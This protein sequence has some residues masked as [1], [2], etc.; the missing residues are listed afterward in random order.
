MEAA[1]AAV[2]LGANIIE[3]HLTLNK[4][5]IGPDHASS[6]T[7]N[8][9]KNMVLSIRKVELCLGKK[10]KPVTKSE[11][12]NIKFVRKSIVA[13]KNISK[14]EV[15][16]E[17]NLS[18]KRPGTGISPLHWYKIMGKKSKKNYKSDDLL[19]KIEIYK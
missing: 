14:G 12:K 7:P 16:S 2:T 3:K 13:K 8:E 1:L 19:K 4:K 10:N 5:L 6:M 18:I 11:K 15:F 17:M 9:F